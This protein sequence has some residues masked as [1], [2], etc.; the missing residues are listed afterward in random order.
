M[1]KTHHYYTY[2]LIFSLVFALTIPSFIFC[3]LAEFNKSKVEDVKLYGK[4]CEL[5]RSKAFDFGIVALICSSIAQIVGNLIIF[6]GFWPNLRET[7]S[8]CWTKRMII[9]TLFTVVSWISFGI[10]MTLT[11]TAT[12]MNKGQ[13]YG[14]GWLNGD[15]YLVKDGVF[16][17]AAILILLSLGCTLASFV[18]LLSNKFHVSSDNHSSSK[19]CNF[20]WKNTITSS[21]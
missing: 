2:T 1:D 6:I 16:I 7:K 20:K 21:T 8:F 13:A 4:W 17:G 18:T 5:P 10:S 3:I 19:G 15:C 11:S 9:A 14:K 12:S